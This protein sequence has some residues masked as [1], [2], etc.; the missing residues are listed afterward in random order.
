M[1]DTASILGVGFCLGTCLVRLSD[2]LC[3]PSAQTF[4]QVCLWSPSGERKSNCFSGHKK[5]SC[6][7]LTIAYHYKPHFLALGC[8]GT[9]HPMEPL[10]VLEA[11]CSQCSA[12]SAWMPSGALLLICIL[13]P[14]LC[15]A[16]SYMIPDHSN[17]HGVGGFPPK[18]HLSSF[19]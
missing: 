18:D 3:P 16:D 4:L 2:I 15:L 5:R 17:A 1:W 7:D 11:L 12:V 19:S 14:L 10:G 13:L 9:L 8:S 6:G